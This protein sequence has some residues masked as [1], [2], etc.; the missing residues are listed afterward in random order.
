[1]E[2]LSGLGDDSWQQT[3]MTKL[4]SEEFLL[5]LNYQRH[6]LCAAIPS[7]GSGCRAGLF[8]AYE[9]ASAPDNAIAKAHSKPTT[10]DSEEFSGSYP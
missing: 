9:A 2:Q 10:M 8:R 3:T 1:M 4:Y 5:S 7:S 6:G